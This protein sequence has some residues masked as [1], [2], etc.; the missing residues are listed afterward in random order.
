MTYQK[1]RAR[2]IVCRAFSFSKGADG[3][4]NLHNY[5]Y[6]RINININT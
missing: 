1:E 6:A 2:H 4:A 5:T 3:P